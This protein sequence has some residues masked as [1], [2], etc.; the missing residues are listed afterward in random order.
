MGIN[1]GLAGMVVVALVVVLLRVRGRNG[2]DLLID[3]Q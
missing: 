3:M 2:P 1:A